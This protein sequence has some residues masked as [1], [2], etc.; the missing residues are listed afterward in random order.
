MFNKKKKRY[1]SFNRQTKRCI[2][3][4]I[5]LQTFETI[6]FSKTIDE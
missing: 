4:T 6:Y 3:I 5:N 1:F 2:K